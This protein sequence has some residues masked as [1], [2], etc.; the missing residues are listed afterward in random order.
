MQI[1]D[2]DIKTFKKRSCTELASNGDLSRLAWDV[3]VPALCNE[4]LETRKKLETA[5]RNRWFNASKL[6]EALGNL[7]AELWNNTVIAGKRKFE[8]YEIADAALA[9]P[10]RNCDRP[11]CGTTKAAQD[12]WRKEDRGATA[13]YEWLLAPATEK[14]RRIQ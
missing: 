3:V 14:E 4:L 7:R 1:T 11:E 6:R 10:P 9:A 12:V 5:T 2:E 8:L 13:Y